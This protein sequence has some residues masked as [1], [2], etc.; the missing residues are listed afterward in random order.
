MFVARAGIRTKFDAG[1]FAAG[2]LKKM[3]S[4]LQL[5]NGKAKS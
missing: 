2:W 3:P 1:P 4:R 5:T